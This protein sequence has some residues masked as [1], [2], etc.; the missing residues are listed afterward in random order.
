MKKKLKGVYY[1]KTKEGKFGV[2]FVGYNL[3]Q[4][5]VICM[6]I[7]TKYQFELKPDKLIDETLKE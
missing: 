5:I 3:I 1:K 2:M 4:L 7:I 6:D